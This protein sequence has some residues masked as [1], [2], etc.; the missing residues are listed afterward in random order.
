MDKPEILFIGAL[1]P[2]YHGVSI[3]NDILVNN[4]KLNN[5]F[6]ISIV[7]IKRDL[8]QMGGA[9]S[10]KTLFGDLGVL[11]R[12][13]WV[14]MNRNPALTYLGI[15]QTRF[16]MWRDICLMRLAKFMKSRT[17]VHLHGG[18]FR[19]L[20]EEK[21]TASERQFVRKTLQGLDGIMVYDE[22]LRWIFQGLVPDD[23][24][25]IL[26]NGLPDMFHGDGFPEV[27]AQRRNSPRLRV[28]YLSNLFPEKGYETFLDAAAVLKTRGNLKDFL[29]NL[30]G[31][32]P[33]EDT[34]TRVEKFVRDHE[35]EDSI[36][37]LGKVL[38]REKRNLLLET[39]I[40]VFPSAYK[41]EGQPLAIIEA[42]SSGLPVIATAQGCIQS[43]QVRDGI[44][45][46]IVEAKNPFQIAKQL[47]VLHENPDLRLRMS[48][49][50]RE[51]FLSHYT[52]DRFAQGLADIVERVLGQD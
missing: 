47:M 2:P 15:G 46:F 34:A 18:Y 8:L 42:L 9:F 14:L 48:R 36:R 11:L 10:I 49:E 50:S 30:A 17:L 4:K 44:N 33:D 38:G 12:V 21:L 22:S 16:G 29:F 27:M 28:T 43:S 39:D 52:E 37:I 19:N 26:A 24:I 41:P 25:F 13:F 23:R 45:G 6:D 31:A 7:Q 20:F 40:F 51:L 35:M 3:M 32:P 1:P 5:K